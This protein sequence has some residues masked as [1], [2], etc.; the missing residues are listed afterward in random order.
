[1]SKQQSFLKL[2]IIFLLCTCIA[3]L[4]AQQSRVDSIVQLLNKIKTS[5]GVDTVK[6]ADAVSM[7][8]KTNLNDESNATLEKTGDLF[9]NGKDEYWSYRVK[10]TILNSLIATDKSKSVVYGKYQLAQLEK[11]KPLMLHG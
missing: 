9:I 3:S 7:I 6:F 1:M 4:Y 2:L 5:K 8:E 11:S 10:Y